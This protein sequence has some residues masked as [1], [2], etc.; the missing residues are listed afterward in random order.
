MPFEQQVMIV[1]AGNDGALDEIPVAKVKAFEKAFLE[2]ATKNYPDIE[3]EIRE[4]KALSDDLKKK[5]Q[6]AIAKFKQEFK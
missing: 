1:F 6:Q 5:L 4:K 2:F 3:H